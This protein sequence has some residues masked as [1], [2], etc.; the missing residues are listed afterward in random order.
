MN[1]NINNISRLILISI[2]LFILPTWAFAKKHSGQVSLSNLSH[3]GVTFKELKVRY[4]LNTLINEPLKS[5]ELNYTPQGDFT[6]SLV[7]LRARL[8]VNG[9]PVNAYVSFSP[10]A[11]KPGK[12]SFDV[13]GSPSWGGLFFTKT[14]EAVPASTAKEYME[15]DITLVDLELINFE[16]LNKAAKNQKGLHKIYSSPQNEK[17]AAEAT[18]SNLFKTEI[19][20]GGCAY[21]DIKPDLASNAFKCQTDQKNINDGYYS[22]YKIT[23]ED[24]NKSSPK[25]VNI[26]IRLKEGNKTLIDGKRKLTQNNKLVFAVRTEKFT[27]GKSKDYD[28]LK[29]NITAN[30]SEKKEQEKDDQAEDTEQNENPFSKK[31]VEKK[32]SEKN[33]FARRKPNETE[34]PFSKK[35][36]LAREAAERERR[37]KARLERE[38]KEREERERMFSQWKPKS[39]FD[40]RVGNI[41]IDNESNRKI[42]VILWH[43]DHKTAFSRHQVYPKSSTTL[44][45]NGKPINI[46]GD[47]GIQYNNPKGIIK[48]VVTDGTW[49]SNQW[50]VKKDGIKEIMG[51]KP[52][53]DKYSKKYGYKDTAGN[54]VIPAQFQGAEKF[55]KDGT[56][57]VGLRYSRRG[58][59]C[60]EMVDAKLAQ[61]D[62][63]G[64]ILKRW[65]S[66]ER[67]HLFCLKSR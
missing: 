56:A 26:T 45:H 16:I 60:N 30:W 3:K 10:I 7:K 48:T 22:I 5:F 46:G 41:V 18:I 62:A 65:N 61:I 38:R 21:L 12:W 24:N 17:T 4:S 59:G 19:N 64:T 34:N 2:F 49:T 6:I 43:P 32:T 51:W 14:G 39:S 20:W 55:T 35:Q 33:P 1:K 42:T 36:R 52:F 50:K 23:Y 25:T 15:N 11:A 8:S 63:Q 29:L 37:E 67:V 28:P 40:G 54:I 47:W 58:R 57:T 13:P 44:E 53:Q 9:I 66:S 31:K 27:L